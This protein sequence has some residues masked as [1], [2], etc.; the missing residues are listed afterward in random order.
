MPFAD[1][2][3]PN[4]S[5]RWKTRWGRPA[6]LTLEQI[7]TVMNWWAARSDDYRPV[8]VRG[9]KRTNAKER[10]RTRILSDPELVEVWSAA[11]TAGGGGGGVCISFV[12]LFGRRCVRGARA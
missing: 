9:M 2:T 8:L 12:L 6:D 7:S 1:P 4:C 3:S 11:K 5:I 10:A